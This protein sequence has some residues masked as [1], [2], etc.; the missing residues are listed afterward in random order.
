M[1]SDSEYETCLRVLQALCRE[2]QALQHEG[3]A[4]QQ[5]VQQ[6]AALLRVRKS[7]RKEAHR[8]RDRKA[9]DSAGIRQRRA[10]AQGLPAVVQPGALP[11]PL[12]GKAAEP[13]PVAAPLQPAGTFLWKSRRCYVCKETYSRLHFFYDSLCTGCA[14]EN[15]RR[16]DQSADLHGRVALITGARIKIGYAA[17][18]K[19]L[20]AGATVLATTRFPAD[21]QRRYQR[22]PDY[23]AWAHRLHIH[24]L[25]LLDPAGVES[26]A[27]AVCAAL[28]HLDIL[29]NNAAQTIRRPPAFYRHLLEDG[30]DHE[31]APGPQ[32][33]RALPSAQA[34]EPQPQG[35]ATLSMSAPLL[36][37]HGPDGAAHVPAEPLDRDGQPLDPRPENSWTLRLAKVSTAELIEVH[38]INCIAPFILIQ[39][40]QPLLSRSPHPHRFVVNVSAMEG[41][42]S[43]PA[44]T[45]RHPHT[46]MAK[47]AL[48]M[49]THTCARDLAQRGIF[50]N[51][52]DTG[53]VTNEFPWPISQDMEAAGFQ[54]PLDEIDGAARVCEPIFSG[55]ATGAPVFGQFLKDYRARA[56]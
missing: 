24:G 45:S 5:V 52:V 3:G 36:R 20:R 32:P 9:V 51:S 40:L 25:D 23:A 41:A 38:A 19:L 8:Q 13:D 33:R 4:Q 27:D 15:Y 55:L 16:R 2:P 39:R 47:A 18:L 11:L 26:F 17:A 6:A 12:P 1:I 34:A 31:G 43:D 50:L 14:A 30:G 46:N 7:L 54:P 10:T 53:W 37:P 29:I 21:A 28:P 44:K 22:E 49:L 48:N 35:A 42:F 56:W